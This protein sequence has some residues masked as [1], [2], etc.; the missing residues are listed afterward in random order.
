VLAEDYQE[1]ADYFHSE[2]AYNKALHLLEKNP[3]DRGNYATALDNIGGLYLAYG[4]AEEAD[5]CRRTAR[6]IRLK[7]GD[8]LGVARSQERLAEV[9]LI[10]HRFKVAGDE[11]DQAFAALNAAG[12]PLFSDRISSL[13]TSAIAHCKRHEYAEGRHAAE[14]ALA[15]SRENFVENSLPVAHSLLA[16]GLAQSYTGDMDQAE[17][18]ILA[19][20]HILEQKSAPD[21]PVV[22]GALYEY[23][24]FL[25]RSHREAQAEA[26][27]RQLDARLTI[28]RSQCGDCSTSV[29]ALVDK[30]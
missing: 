16:L 20:V 1:T 15:M 9:A 29:F 26:L 30:R 13:V 12:D 25:Q 27:S 11:A 3:A 24:N 18:S 17:R 14:Q 5:R 23:R 4:R 28:M 21:S 8:Q 6:D 10:E 22:L 2:D 19:G 7:L